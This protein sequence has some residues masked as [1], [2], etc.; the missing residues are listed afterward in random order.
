MR[1]LALVSLAAVAVAVLVAAV[2][3]R[4]TGPGAAKASSHREAPLISQDPTADNTDL[5]AFVSPDK[6]DT[7][8]IIANW[9][10][11]EDPAAGPNYYTFSTSARY[12]IY[13][14]K[15]GDGK[16]DITYYF[17]F[18]DLPCQFFLGQNA[19]AYTVTKVVNGKV[20]WSST[21]SWTRAG[22]RRPRW[23]R[24]PQPRGCGS[25]FAGRRL[26]GLRRPA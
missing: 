4:G 15:N 14:D 24:L 16:P 6:P 26:D 19:A 13:V 11:G 23:T 25:S 7:A 5:Y 9:I 17:R 3:T 2:A 8:T 18:S 22:Q 1:K 12:D 10:P 20:R 21:G